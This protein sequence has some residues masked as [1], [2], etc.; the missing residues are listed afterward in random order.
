MASTSRLALAISLTITLL[1]GAVTEV[2]AVEAVSD[3]VSASQIIRKTEEM[4]ASLVSYSDEGQTVA[5]SGGNAITFT[6]RLARRN[7][8]LIEWEKDDESSF[9]PSELRAQAVWSSGAG[10]YVEE[11]VGVQNTLSRDYALA[12]A[13][14]PSGGAAAI[15]PMTFF[16]LHL[17]WGDTFGGSE[18]KEKRQADEKVGNVDCYV[19]TGESQG[20]TKTLWIGKRDYLIRQIR[21]IVSTEALRVD[22][23]NWIPD[24]TPYIHGFNW[25][26]THTNIVVN[27]QFARTDFLPTFP[28]RGFSSS[29]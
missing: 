10:D 24:Q 1:S 26:E 13:A 29:E 20:Q 3:D 5:D 7:F 23:A 9:V 11:E 8:Y 16:H 28:G 17:E 4:Y 27:K 14:T 19:I 6:I 18:L 15:I 22:I 2:F 21:T 25:T 12:Q